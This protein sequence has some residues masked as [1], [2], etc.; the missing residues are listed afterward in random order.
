MTQLRRADGTMNKDHHP[1]SEDDFD[2]IQ[3]AVMETER[4][5]WF[6]AEYA[7]RNRNSDTVVLLD[8]IKKLESTMR[9]NPAPALPAADDQIRFDL[10]EMANAISQ[11]KREIA[12]LKSDS[13]QP[14]GIEIATEE[15][16]AI[17]TSTET[18]TQ[19]ILEAAENV[20]ELAW[21]MREDGV[22]EN[23][24]EAIDN[25]VT[26]IYT[27]CSFQDL[28]GQR[29]SKV[30]AVLRYLEQ[31]L[32]AM[33]KIWGAETEAGTS[34]E[35]SDTRPDAHLLNGPQLDKDAHSQDDID[36]I[37]IA[38]DDYAEAN[39]E[40]PAA[41][42]EASALPPPSDETID[43]P[44]AP[45][46]EA[47]AVAE[48]DVDDLDAAETLEEEA[49]FAEEDVEFEGADVFDTADTEDPEE[50]IIDEENVEDTVEPPKGRIIMV[51]KPRVEDQSEPAEDETETAEETSVSHRQDEEAEELLAGAS[52]DDM[53][54]LFT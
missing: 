44:A 45:E 15:L 20:Q 12:S 4:G 33:C 8:A 46:F 37:M 10:V 1:L 51:R 34:D 7:D 18:A 28:T 11:T 22:P 54:A 14:S 30:V 27:A 38:D 47:Q 25:L 35:L 53:M 52:K 43:E 36:V 17:V 5:R 16:D 24:C 19:D 2:A 39:D 23:Y 29:I 32:E 42:A 50:L 41:T 6:L 31:R 9:D 26:A 40:E 49:L 21:T 13:D 3:A 48:P